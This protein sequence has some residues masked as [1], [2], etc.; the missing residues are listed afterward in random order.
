[1]GG[2]YLKIIQAIYEIPTSNIILN[3]EK[4]EDFP[5]KRGTRQG[6]SLSQLLF[7]T[8]PEVLA[9]AI[10]QKERSKSHLI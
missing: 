9:T 4:P 2:H 5:L 8:A 6:C 10:R 1:M 7:N 3:S